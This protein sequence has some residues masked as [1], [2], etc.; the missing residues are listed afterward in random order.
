MLKGGVSEFSL[1]WNLF[2]PAL[3]KITH[4][5]VY[6]ILTI[7]AHQACHLHWNCIALHCND[8]YFHS[9]WP[10]FQIWPNW[11]KKVNLLS[12]QSKWSGL[13]KMVILSENSCHCNAMQCNFNEGDKLDAHRP[14]PITVCWIFLWKCQVSKFNDINKFRIEDEIIKLWEY[15]TNPDFLDMQL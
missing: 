13:K 3:G 1:I 15:P 9:K 4:W 10:F 8:N 6:Y 14:L 7:Y 12:F 2:L 11:L 5:W